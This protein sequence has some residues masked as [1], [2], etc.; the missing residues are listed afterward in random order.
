MK[1]DGLEMSWKT[2]AVWPIG[3]RINCNRHGEYC[4]RNQSAGISHITCATRFKYYAP[5][6]A[7]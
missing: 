7:Q 1:I 5:I 6:A 2:S 4:R 3:Q